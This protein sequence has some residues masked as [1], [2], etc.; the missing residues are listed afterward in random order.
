MIPFLL[1]P[2]LTFSF[3][4]CGVLFLETLQI[5]IKYVLAPLGEE[6]S[7]GRYNT[8]LALDATVYLITLL[9]DFHIL[10]LHGLG[11]SAVD[12]FL[13]FQIRLLFVNLKKKVQQIRNYHQLNSVLKDR[14]VSFPFSFLLVF[15]FFSSE[16]QYFCPGMRQLH[17]KSLKVETVERF[18]LFVE[19]K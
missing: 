17:K 11:I 19:M 3:Q 8:D 9:H 15:F 4:K 10:F 6:A 12:L 18:V 13:L 5:L 7:R 14:F 2:F 16:Q 1:D